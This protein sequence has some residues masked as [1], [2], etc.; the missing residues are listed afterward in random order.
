MRLSAIFA[1]LV[2]GLCHRGIEATLTAVPLSTAVIT[3]SRLQLNCASDDE[4]GQFNW[5]YNAI[6]SVPV[7]IIYNCQVHPDFVGQYD[8]VQ[9]IQGECHLVIA[10]TNMNSA[11]TY[12]CQNGFD[13][14]TA[15]VV[16]LNSN[17]A[18][19]AIP[20]SDLIGG[21][22]IRIR[23]VINY[24]GT[25]VPR[26][27]WTDNS[28]GFPISNETTSSFP[29]QVNSYIDV[30]VYPPAS[31]PY[32]S[33]TYF[34]PPI[35]Y[36]YTWL[37]PTL[38]VQFAATNVIATA[39]IKYFGDSSVVCAADGY[40]VPTY[41]WTNLN[42][43]ATFNGSTLPISSNG[44]GR[45]ECAA[46]NT[47][48]GV[49]QTVRTTLATDITQD[50]PEY[51]PT[52]PEP[53]TTTEAPT[54]PPPT[55]PPT[56]SEATTVTTTTVTPEPAGPCGRLMFEAPDN[57]TSP[58]T[59]WSVLCYISRSETT[60]LSTP[61]RDLIID[62]PPGFPSYVELLRAGGNFGCS[63]TTRSDYL[64]APNACYDNYQQTTTLASCGSC[65][66]LFVCIRVP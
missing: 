4:T 23:C 61:C 38:Y 37:L 12:T 9:T 10:T 62:L 1:L 64:Q 3:G 13:Q 25:S 34:D 40:P 26:M 8:V 28:T 31:R 5:L 66:R 30:P 55:D 49:T 22:I 48:R 45:Y 42:T 14:A 52:T 24:N 19:S 43:G 27:R 41:R 18:C 36:T 53:T 6:N 51:C 46:S 65:P 47:I 2:L 50:V 11:G 56:T 39:R 15:N 33:T 17:S 59:G 21:D 20:S 7:R 44:V 57:S 60:L 58:P 29:S 32:T 35:T 16:M 54:T 63:L